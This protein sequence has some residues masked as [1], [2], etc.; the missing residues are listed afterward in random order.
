MAPLNSPSLSKRTALVVIVGL[1]VLV[2]LVF[3]A[4]RVLGT[5]GTRAPI[6][7]SG[8]ESFKHVD[9]Q[10]ALGPRPPGSEANRK[11]GDYII[12]ELKRLGWQ[13]ETQEFTYKDVPARNIIGKA[14]L[15]QG[16]VIIVGAHYDTRLFADQDQTA[17]TSP[18]PGANDGA[19]GVAV[20]LELARALEVEDLHN[21]VWL[22]FF[23][24]E[25]NGDINGWSWIVGSQ[26]MADNLTITP[27]AM[28][29]VDMIGDA[30]QQ[31]YYDANS[32]Q[33]LSA[34]LFQIAAGLGFG[35]QFIPQPKYAMLDD[36]TPFANRG[37]PAVDLI[38]FDYP[39]WHTT[40]DTADKLSPASLERVGRVIETFLEPTP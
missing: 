10:M 32:N 26:Y 16:P 2:G 25:D 12:S 39:H 18:V 14:A 30:D 31:I 33:A 20:L 38:D 7:F 11:T 21:E 15:G 17:P 35:D 28:I 34:E 36:H 24:V 40:Q 37:I 3:G 6:R 5:L 8:V 23:D 4:W 1:I 29:L 27:Q 19:S 22:A 13:T 9:A